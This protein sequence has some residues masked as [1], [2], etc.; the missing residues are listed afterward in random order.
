MSAAALPFQ[1]RPCNLSQ[2]GGRM[3]A[4]D[5]SSTTGAGGCVIMSRPFF[6][7]TAGN[8]GTV[9]Q[10]NTRHSL[11]DAPSPHH[12]V[13]AKPL[14]CPRLDPGM[15]LMRALLSEAHAS[16]SFPS[17]R[18]WSSESKRC[19]RAS[20]TTPA[21][22]VTACCASNHW[23]VSAGELPRRDARTERSKRHSSPSRKRTSPSNQDAV[24]M[25]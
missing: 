8:P 1:P 20:S 4:V 13:T 18:K 23:R 21:R 3:R 19:R 7:M 10:N 6:G 16:M 12:F 14:A 11:C 25:P 17:T 9:R 2:S 22:T 5:R 15:K 24:P